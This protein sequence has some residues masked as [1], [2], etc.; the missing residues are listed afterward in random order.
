LS[1]TGKFLL[2]AV[3]VVVVP[4]GRGPAY[5]LDPCAEAFL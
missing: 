3:V 5:T 1:T 2:Q 4:S